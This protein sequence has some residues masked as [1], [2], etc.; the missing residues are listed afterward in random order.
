MIAKTEITLKNFTRF[1]P[2]VLIKFVSEVE[3]ARHKF[4]D[5][6]PSFVTQH[7]TCPQ[8]GTECFYSSIS[9]NI[10]LSFCGIKVIYNR[11]SQTISTT[12]G[13]Q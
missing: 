9:L 6:V 3:F 7:S 2:C 11:L 8:R 5:S 10:S 1:L 12:R 13:D 4:R